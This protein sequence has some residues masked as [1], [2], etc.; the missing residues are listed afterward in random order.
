MIKTIH[1]LIS[2]RKNQKLKQIKINQIQTKKLKPLWI[3]ILLQ[4]SICCNRLKLCLKKLKEWKMA[5]RNLTKG[6]HLKTS[7]K[8]FLRLRKLKREK[9]HK[10]NQK[11]MSKVNLI[12][13]MENL[14]KK[15]IHRNNRLFWIS[16]MT[17]KSV[18]LL[19]YHQR[20]WYTT[21]KQARW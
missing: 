19:Q 3:T 4:F 9:T 11:N 1:L 21:W 5:R 8:S 10:K 18:R 7:S 20:S 14:N 12:H 13:L 16:L 17:P 15:K 6:H 2:D